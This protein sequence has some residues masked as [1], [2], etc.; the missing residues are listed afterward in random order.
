M[1]AH[2]CKQATP[3]SG[4]AWH[5]SINNITAVSPTFIICGRN[6]NTEAMVLIQV[7]VFPYRY[8]AKS[9]PAAHTLLFSLDE[10]TRLFEMRVTRR[11]SLKAR[12]YENTAG[13][14]KK[15]GTIS[16]ETCYLVTT[17]TWELG[18]RR[19]GGMPPPLTNQPHQFC[20]HDMV[21]ML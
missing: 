20:C 14:G 9:A 12:P 7:C 5:P 11:A 3:L 4:A 6:G 13:M 8:T 1:V 10:N 19:V 15:E 18:G 2:Q 16:W 17:L 21:S